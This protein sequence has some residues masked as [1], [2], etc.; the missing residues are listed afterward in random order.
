MGRIAERP[1]VPRTAK[2][3]TRVVMPLDEVSDSEAS[4]IVHMPR[5]IFVDNSTHMKDSGSS[6]DTIS[7]GSPESSAASSSE[8]C[9]CAFR[10]VKGGHLSC[11]KKV[12]KENLVQV[13]V[14]NRTMLHVAVKYGHLDVIDYLL[15]EAP[16]LIDVESNTKDTPV[17]VAATAGK[18]EVLERLL[19]GPMKLCQLRAMHRDING[20]S[21]LMAAVA[22]HDNE[23]AL[24]LL[25][26]FG[27]QLAILPN[28]Y[29]MI[30]I[31]VAAANGNIEF[32]RI[33]TKYDPTMIN[34]RD[35]YGCSPCTYAAQSG[36]LNC[37]RFMIEKGRADMSTLTNKGQ[38]LLHV[39][40]LSGRLLIVRWLLY[41][42][43]SDA[44]L[45]PTY[46]K[47]NAVHCAAFGGSVDVAKLLLGL[48][49]KK[50]RRAILT[51]VDAR[52]NTPLHLAAI[53]NQYDMVKY[54]IEVGS[55][56]KLLNSAGQSAEQIATRRGYLDVADVLS[57]FPSDKKL[58]KDKKFSQSCTDLVASS[59]GV[60]N[61]H[62]VYNSHDNSIPGH[63]RTDTFD[64]SSG[65]LSGG[66]DF[67]TN[68]KGAAT[69]VLH[70]K[71]EIA[72]QTEPD[73][74]SAKDHV[75]S[76]NTDEWRGEALAAVEE[77]DKVL[78]A[79]GS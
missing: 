78:D 57:N 14:E 26:R 23:T 37:L 34:R 74:F 35:K 69:S 25:R 65:F 49:P 46:D 61:N 22:R 31:H 51:S 67:N 54:L 5:R 76:Y 30:P 16:H 48:W 8:C 29:E 58:K 73:L 1:L 56:P 28:N 59:E 41:R 79:L 64:S 15:R 53:N 39:S 20:T 17:L 45:Y 38:S 66:E 55:N 19:T 43:G 27:R 42:T 50:R 52:G 60:Y 44:I 70:K 36:S 62:T 40:A 72:T 11:L 33:V 7:S 3:V 6:P 13:D 71:A 77:I 63:G 32:L 18:P 75:P 9:S 10:A 12:P 4:S 47:A 21:C 2:K 68:S 24:W